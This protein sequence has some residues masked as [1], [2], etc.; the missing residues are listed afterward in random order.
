MD[1]NS[2]DDIILFTHLIKKILKEREN[3]TERERRNR[4]EDIKEN[5]I[6][7]NLI[8]DVTAYNTFFEDMY[9][10]LGEDLYYRHRKLNLESAI[11]KTYKELNN[12]QKNYYRKIAREINNELYAINYGER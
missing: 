12:Y 1:E 3:E 10:E 11:K 4:A 8:T 9:R 6:D 5:L 2:S 7:A